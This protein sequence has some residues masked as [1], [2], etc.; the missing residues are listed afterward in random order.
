VDKRGR[1][2]QRLDV[3]QRAALNLRV[4]EIIQ[5]VKNPDAMAVV[6]QPFANVRADETRAAGDEKIHAATLTT[7]APPVEHTKEFGFERGD[8][9]VSLRTILR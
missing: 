2:A 9:S 4:V 8:F 5:V 6:E 1:L 3:R 7:P